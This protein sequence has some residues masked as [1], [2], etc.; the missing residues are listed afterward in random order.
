VESDLLRDVMWYNIISFHFRLVLSFSLFL[1][2]P[3]F[4]LHW[5]GNDQRDWIM[6][7]MMMVVMMASSENDDAFFLSKKRGSENSLW[8]FHFS[9]SFILKKHCFLISPI[10]YL[11]AKTTPPTLNESHSFT[12]LSLR[13]MCSTIGFL[14][15][16]F[17]GK[18]VKISSSCRCYVA[19][20]M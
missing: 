16:E 12:T 3:S 14:T 6:D 5:I 11:L 18:K 17:L 2:A 4:C 7:K 15:Y 13:Q 1:D 20:A 9:L 10:Y 8:S 19:T